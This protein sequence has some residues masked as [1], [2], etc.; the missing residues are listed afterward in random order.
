MIACMIVGGDSLPGPDNIYVVGSLVFVGVGAALVGLDLVRDRR[1]AA[2]VLAQRRTDLLPEQVAVLSGGL[3]RVCLVAVLGLAERGDVAFTR[4]GRLR[5][6]EARTTSAAPLERLAFAAVQRARTADLHDV[7]QEIRR[8]PAAR[9]LLDGLVDA[10]LIRP[11]GARFARGPSGQASWLQAVGVSLS[12]VALIV[13]PYLALSLLAGDDTGRA[14][15]E[16]PAALGA[17][18]SGL[19]LLACALRLVRRRT[20]AGTVVLRSI[21]DGPD[22]RPAVAL[23]GPRRIRDKSVRRALRRSSAPRYTAGGG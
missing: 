4:R 20:R 2:A 21:P 11:W 7:Q 14:L 9:E 13:A 5:V 23:A 22:E 1:A 3:L 10:G 17:L 8:R 15:D 6:T 12:A 16:E 18:G 19:F